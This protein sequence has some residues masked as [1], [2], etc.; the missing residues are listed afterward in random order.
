M[1]LSLLAPGARVRPHAG[2]T[3]ARLRLHCALLV[4]PDLATGAPAAVL[5]VGDAPPRPWPRPWPAAAGATSAAGGVQSCF[6]FRE[7]C[8]HEAS[9]SPRARGPRAVLLADFA[10]PFLA[11]DADY[12]AA[13]RPSP[14][15]GARAAALA[16]RSEC[17]AR[18][19]AGLGAEEG[20]LQAARRQRRVEL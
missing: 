6:V 5:R 12:L 9:V 4:P 18:W 15:A 2:P 7:A 10:N 1:K 3:D 13:L 19:R 8:E 17:V 16:E 20:L 14:G 11:R